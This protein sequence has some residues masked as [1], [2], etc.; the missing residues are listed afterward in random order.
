MSHYCEKCGK[1]MDDNQFYTS[2]NIEKYPPDGRL[3][4]CK[5]CLT[6]HVDN[7]DPETYK[8]ILEEVD[9]PYIKSQWDKLLEKYTKEKDPSKI[10]GLTILGRY[11]A[12]MKLV[13]YKDLRWADTEQIAEKERQEMINTMKAQGISQKDIDTRLATDMTPEKPAELMG[14]E[15]AGEPVYT[16]PA[17]IP[18]AFSDKLTDEDK[19]MLRLKWGSGYT[20]EQWVRMEQLYQDFISSYDIQ[21]AG[22]KDTLIM[23]CKASLKANELLNAGDIDGAQKMTKVYDSLMKSGNF[24]GVQNKNTGVEGI[25][26]VGE[27]VRLAE[28]KGFIPRY[29]VGSP[30]DSV[31]KIL[32][33]LQHYTRTLVTEEMN[34]GNM[35]EN[36]LA[37]IQED[38]KREENIVVDTSDEDEVV[39]DAYQDELEISDEDIAE[40]NERQEELRRQD[41]QA[42]NDG[43]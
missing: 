21:T 20:C 1:T 12:K 10:T 5:K 41:E 33:D 34:L 4:I 17:D 15:E 11:L 38:K 37:A 18:D 27:I 24:Q 2:R 3:S 19:Q 13:Q 23:V 26:S 32:E 28:K 31:D 22:H 6:M 40:F 7:W 8:W 42:M 9:V 16:D 35:I 25:D 29:Y 30:K 36:A 14:V 39:V 43:T